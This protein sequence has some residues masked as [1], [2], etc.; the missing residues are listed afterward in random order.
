MSESNRSL[1]DSGNQSN[2]ALRLLSRRYLGGTFGSL[3]SLS[4]SFSGYGGVTNLPTINFDNKKG[5]GRGRMTEK[6]TLG[7]I[8]AFFSLCLMADYA[9]TTTGKL[10]AL[11]LALAISL[12]G[13]LRAWGLI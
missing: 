13:T 1:R 10:I 2:T 7:F 4:L 8:V 9:E 6:E 11:I 3:F 12:W 5:V